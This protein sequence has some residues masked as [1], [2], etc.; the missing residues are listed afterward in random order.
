[1]KTKQQVLT[2][3]EGLK[4]Y[5][6]EQGKD[7]AKL[8]A[9]LAPLIKAVN[10]YYAVDIAKDVEKAI[11]AITHGLVR[12]GIVYADGSSDGNSAQ[13]PP[14]YNDV[15]VFFVSANRQMTLTTKEAFN[16]SINEVTPEASVE[17]STPAPYYESS[18]VDSLTAEYTVNATEVIEYLKAI[19][20]YGNSAGLGNALQKLLEPKEIKSV[21]SMGDISKDI[22]INRKYK[23]LIEFQSL[24]IYVPA[25]LGGE[26]NA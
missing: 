24:N 16:A 15:T 18:L 25:G 17:G 9:L 5:A 11:E 14:G 1:M 19:A 4:S 2:H 21:P 22:Y 6:I 23:D 20:V 26:G 12:T 7:S 3:L 8:T 13:E 10:D